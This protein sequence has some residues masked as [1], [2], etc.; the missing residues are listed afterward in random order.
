VV[1]QFIILS[2]QDER[3]R[4]KLKQMSYTG[5]CDKETRGQASLDRS[6]M[7]SSKVYNTTDY[8]AY[9][10]TIHCTKG[11]TSDCAKQTNVTP[12]LGKY[13]GK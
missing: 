1:Y 9:S 8:K 11:K 12:M 10:A 6:A 3:S 13:G 2:I 5:G 7:E 4:T